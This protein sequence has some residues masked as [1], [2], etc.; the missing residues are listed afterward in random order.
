MTLATNPMMAFI[1]VALFIILSTVIF[2][3]VRNNLFEQTF[4]AVVVSL[5][6]TLLGVIGIHRSLFDGSGQRSVTDNTVKGIGIDFLLIPYAALA[7][8]ILLIM[9]LLLLFKLSGVRRKERNYKS[10]ERVVEEQT[11]PEESSRL[12]E[13]KLKKKSSGLKRVR[14]SKE[15]PQVKRTS[16]SAHNQS[17]CEYAH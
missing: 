11:K 7:I 1:A 13:T 3:V 9:L 16:D 5:C 14:R 10:H 2:K 6:V 4:A 8:A 17:N 15:S 12:P